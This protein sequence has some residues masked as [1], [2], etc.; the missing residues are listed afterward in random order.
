V[1]GQD[2]G[3]D[4]LGIWNDMGAHPGGGPK[5]RLVDQMALVV[6]V[7]QYDAATRGNPILAVH[8]KLYSR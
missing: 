2:R 5:G 8:G 6:A 1:L 4:L 3:F 7:I